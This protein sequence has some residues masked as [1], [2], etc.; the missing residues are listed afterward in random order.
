M[1]M[2][3]QVELSHKFRLLPNFIGA[4]PADFD[5]ESAFEIARDP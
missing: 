5:I 3:H 2:R 1:S 4:F